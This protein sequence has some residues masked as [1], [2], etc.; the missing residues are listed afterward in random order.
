[1]RPIVLPLLLLVPL[2]ACGDERPR[3]AFPA[4]STAPLEGRLRAARSCDSLLEQLK[5]DARTRVATQAWLSYESRPLVDVPGGFADAGV[6]TGLPSPAEDGAGAPRGHTDT[7]VQVEGVDEAD[8]VETNGESI[9]LLHGDDLFVL[10]SWPPESSAVTHVVDIEGTTR[11]LF[12]ADGKAVVISET[13]DAAA[14]VG[15]DGGGATT[16]D[17]LYPG[18]GTTRTK[19]TVLDVAAGEPSVTSERWLEGSYVSA[20]RHG[21]VVR[22]LVSSYSRLGESSPPWLYFDSGVAYGEESA[23]RSIDAWRT[24]ELARIEAAT[25]DDVLPRSER[26]DGDSVVRVPEDCTSFYLPPPGVASSG[27]LRVATVDAEDASV[28]GSTVIVGRADTVYA[29][30]EHLVVAQNDYRFSRFGGIAAQE[31]ALHVF[32]LEGTDTTYR[33]SGKVRGSVSGQFAL[34]MQEDVLRLALTEDRVVGEPSTD[35]FVGFVPTTPVTAVSTV[36]VSDEALVAL[37]RTEDLA[38]GERMQSVRFIG[39]RAYVVTFLRTDPLF[40]IDVSKPN[41]LE[42]LAE[43]IIPGFSEYVHPLAPGYLLT[44]GREV[45]PDTGWDEGLALSIFDVRAD[46]DP[47][48]LDRLVVQGHSN[49][50]WDHHDFIFDDAHGV[51]AIPL[52]DYT[53]TFETEL[54]LFDVSIAD[55]VSARG[56]IP[57]TQFFTACE[58][59]ADEPWWGYYSCGYSPAV[60]RGLFIDDYVYSISNGGML[61]HTLD[62]L[63]KVASVPLPAPVTYYGYFPPWRGGPIGF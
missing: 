45:N 61:V 62:G 18:Y 11:G 38:P 7:N 34:D 43:L 52:Y 58:P 39:D 2:A 9:F 21:S 44:I 47:I 25:I 10:D 23:Y 48:L 1:M 5:A 28:F 60:R 42:V 3:S 24:A 29:N 32:A 33:T 36:R 41:E 51:L 54:A 53:S 49:A 12:L 63:S 40:V 31:V 56:R 8:F 4:P 22:V 27:M 50:E 17:S 20:R 19:V 57:H 14:P 35:P 16:G 37:D 55:G 26:R 15:E 46:D 6:V 13:Y 59:P 30:A